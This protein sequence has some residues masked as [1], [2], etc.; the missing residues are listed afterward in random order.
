MNSSRD[1]P[2][3][4]ILLNGRGLVIP[5][6]MIRNLALFSGNEEGLPEW[7]YFV[8]I[9]EVGGLEASEPLE[10]MKFCF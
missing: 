9:K 8:R 3:S 5:T 2:Y 4:D 1:D 10:P 6:E 7:C